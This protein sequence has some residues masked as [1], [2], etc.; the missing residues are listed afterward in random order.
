[1]T[2]Q[3][4]CGTMN[5]SGATNAT[6]KL[7]SVQASNDGNYS[8]IVSNSFGVVVSANASLAVL[9]DGANGNQPVQITPCTVPVKPL[10][11]SSLIVVTHGFA[12]EFGAT[13]E[14]WVLNMCDAISN[15]VPST[16][17]VVPYVWNNTA[18]G[19]PALA[20]KVAQIE[21]KLIGPTLAQ[22]D[23][24]YVHLIGHSAGA[25][26]VKAVADQIKL[27]SPSTIVHCTFLDPYT[28]RFYELQNVYGVNANWSDCYTAEDWTGPWTDGQLGNAFNVDVSWL[29]PNRTIAFYGTWNQD[30]ALSSHGW[31][32]GFYMQSITNTDPTWAGAN[33]GFSL[34]AEGGGWANHG[35]LPIGDHPLM[36][37]GSPTAIQNPNPYVAGL[38]EIGLTVGSTVITAGSFLW[39]NGFG[40]NTLGFPMIQ[41]GQGVNG[42]LYDARATDAATPAWI[43]VSVTVTSKVNFVSFE[44]GFNSTNPAEGMLTVYWNTN[45][46]GVADERVDSV[47]VQTN[48]F[49]LPET[50]MDGVYSLSFRLDSFNGTNSSIIV[51]NLNLGYSGPTNPLSVGIQSGAGGTSMVVTVNGDAGYNYLVQASTNLDDWMPFALLP[52]TNG[53]VTCSDA[54]STNGNRRFYRATLP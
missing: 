6:L 32:V 20:L 21:G 44:S 24:Q 41:S 16:C 27:T 46:I 33:Y 39:N 12:P 10:G 54:G 14:S 47:A 22:G 52:N 4:R 5:I 11:A 53:T 2:Y 8:V 43:A 37:G 1:M 51:T 50:V 29:D 13:D 19:V 17:V 36:L 31:P 15:R 48:V 40:L 25:G 23:W 3:W 35:T 38:T 30:I 7:N 34:S 49:F 26:F 28:G 45:Q 9:T 42:V 18:G